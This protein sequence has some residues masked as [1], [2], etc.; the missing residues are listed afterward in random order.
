[1]GSNSITTVPGIKMTFSIFCHAV[2]KCD[3]Y[4]Y[5]P[6]KRVDFNV[7]LLPIGKII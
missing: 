1:M 3:T 6:C 7:L 5:S 2:I 4:L